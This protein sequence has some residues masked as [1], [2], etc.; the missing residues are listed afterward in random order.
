[1]LENEISQKIFKVY[2]VY[3][4]HEEVRQLNTALIISL[5]ELCMWTFR[6]E[7]IMFRFKVINSNY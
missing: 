2:A 3:R 7:W 5:K 6:P 1:M 4:T